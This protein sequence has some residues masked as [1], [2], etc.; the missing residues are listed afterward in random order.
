MKVLSTLFV[1]ALLLASQA[2]AGKE[3]W[4]NCKG[5]SICKNK[6]LGLSKPRAPNPTLHDLMEAAEWQVN[7]TKIYDDGHYAACVSPTN[8]RPVNTGLGLCAYPYD[9]G[10]GITGKMI[11]ELLQD[12][13][14]YH[15]KRCGM[16]SAFRPH[17]AISNGYLA[18]NTVDNIKWEQHKPMI[19][20]NADTVH[21]HT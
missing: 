13:D 4:I 19:A 11:K 9:T 8:P 17:L 18:V 3:I 6:H 20:D 10:H 16:V 5:S 15:C 12:L 21:V 1:P 7:D 14:D 2:L